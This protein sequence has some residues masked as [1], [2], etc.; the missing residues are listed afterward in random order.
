MNLR[1]V[2]TFLATIWL[3]LIQ[4]KAKPNL[5]TE[6]SYAASTEALK[7]LLDLEEMLLENLK[8]YV[9][10]L[11]HKLNLANR[12]LINFRAKDLKMRSDNEYLE[13]PLNSFA[14]LRHQNE[15]WLRWA[16]Y[17]EKLPGTAHIAYA[18]NIRS[19]L[20]THTDLKEASNSI[21]LLIN[22]YD[23]KPNDL[24]NGKLA[25]LSQPNTALSMLDCN[26]L[27]KFN[28]FQRN[29]DKAEIWFNISL[30][31]Y[32]AKH[33]LIYKAFDFDETHIL[34]WVGALLVKRKEHVTGLEHLKRANRLVLDENTSY[35]EAAQ[36]LMTQLCPASMHR[37]TNLHC[38]YNNWMTPFLRIAPLKMEELNT[39]PFVVIYYDAIYDSEIEWFLK[40]PSNFTPSLLEQGELSN[41]R[42]AQDIFIEDDEDEVTRTLHKRIIDMTG[43]S[44]EEGDRL[45][46]INYGIGGHYEVHLDS[47]A[48]ELEGRGNRIATVLF[49]MGHIESGGATIFPQLNLT[50]NPER[51]T[52]LVWHNLNND[53]S[54]NLNT[55]H[56]AC[57][58]VV[59]TKYVLT[60]WIFSI[61][62]MFIK[63][64]L[65]IH[66][67]P[68][69]KA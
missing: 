36:L 56:S 31:K 50:V 64:C 11:K 53:G 44:M 41:I 58:V 25:G 9:S 68:V 43:F 67:K 37:P 2:Y 62:Q 60:K 48:Q 4:A 33:I 16:S 45:S 69:S 57:P 6:Y 26:A 35:F 49:Y 46:M 19:K 28:L 17:M 32:D 42:T 63:P 66:G 23:L 14:L 27:G 59:G 5:N 61:D 51:G 65:A 29:Y 10:E 7:K 8:D 21:E 22:Y 38:R 13:N 40:T 20:P 15:D 34:K 12:T 54:K 55:W 52:A 47:F 18:H 30:A 1:K 39:D 3:C 24:A